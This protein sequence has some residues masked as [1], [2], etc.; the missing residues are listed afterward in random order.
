MLLTFLTV[1]A[2]CSAG[3]VAVVRYAQKIHTEPFNEGS[4]SYPT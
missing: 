2:V 3:G 1:L 4:A